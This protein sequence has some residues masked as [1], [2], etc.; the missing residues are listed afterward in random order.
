MN[1]KCVGSTRLINFTIRLIFQQSS[2]NNSIQPHQQGGAISRN[3]SRHRNHGLPTN[4]Q[5]NNNFQQMMQQQLSQQTPPYHSQLPQ[6]NSSS[7]INQINPMQS[8][9]GGPSSSHYH[10]HASQQAMA[11]AV[12]EHG[13][14]NF[15]TIRTT[16]IVTKQQKE[17]MQVR[18]RYVNYLLGLT[19]K[20]IIIYVRPY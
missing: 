14:N 17:H 16:S 10:N 7:S 6:Q 9:S 3:S 13:A 4:V 12:S 5:M 2:S 8:V 11:N 19:L 15:A 20:T 1:S 18:F